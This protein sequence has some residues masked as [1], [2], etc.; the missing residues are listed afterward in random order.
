MHVAYVPSRQTSTVPFGPV[1]QAVRAL[2]AIPALVRLP[3]VG[4][5]FAGAA[6]AIVNSAIEARIIVFID[7]P[8]RSSGQVKKARAAARV[9]SK[10]ILGISDCPEKN[11]KRE[12]SRFS[13][14]T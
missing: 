9:L 6:F 13:C 2:Q 7:L 8:F 12:S 10:S 4:A 3:A 11:P 1:L 14:Y 5:A